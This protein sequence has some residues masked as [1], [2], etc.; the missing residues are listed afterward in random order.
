MYYYSYNYTRRMGYIQLSAMDCTLSS[1][2]LA[3]SF[4]WSVRVNLFAAAVTSRVVA[5]RR[6]C[7][8]MER[9]KCVLV[10][11]L[12]FM[13]IW[14]CIKIVG[15]SNVIVLPLLWSYITWCICTWHRENVANWF[16]VYVIW[17]PCVDVSYYTSHVLYL[18]V[19]LKLL[20]QPRVQETQCVILYCDRIICR[21]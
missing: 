17:K 3:E 13:Q 21:L 4:E 9:F 6:T 12:V 5:L 1:V 15:V 18:Y 16:C 2:T 10:K 19:D 7:K 14:S 11:Q 8:Q 20:Q